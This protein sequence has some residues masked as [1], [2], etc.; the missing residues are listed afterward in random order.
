MAHHRHL[1][2]HR[3][4]IDRKTQRDAPAHIGGHPVHQ[5]FAFI[6]PQFRHFGRQPKRRDTGHAGRKAYLGLD[7]H[8][9]AVQPF[10]GIKQRIQD[11]VDTAL[12][13]QTF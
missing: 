10:I 5:G 2:S 7:A 6:K 11:G 1:F 13:C 3:L 8:R 12:H 4:A 9:G